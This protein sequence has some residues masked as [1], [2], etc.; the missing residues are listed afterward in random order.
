MEEENH[1]DIFPTIKRCTTLVVAPLPRSSLR[2]AEV[3]N[4][5]SGRTNVCSTE[6]E[7]PD[8]TT[9]CYYIA[10]TRKAAKGNNARKKRATSRVKERRLTT[11]TSYLR[12]TADGRTLDWMNQA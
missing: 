10:L 4:A 2:S 7:R 8:K 11:V 6:R 9:C 12:N 3:R 5:V 1:R